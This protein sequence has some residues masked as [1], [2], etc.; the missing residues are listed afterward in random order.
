M[1]DIASRWSMGTHLTLPLPFNSFRLP[2]ICKNKVEHLIFKH[3]V[4]YTWCW[5]LQVYSNHP[6]TFSHIH[7]PINIL[8]CNDFLPKHGINYCKY[9]FRDVAT[10]YFTQNQLLQLVTSHHLF[11]QLLKKISK[12]SIGCVAKLQ[13][14][15]AQRH[16]V[17]FWPP[18]CQPKGGCLK[19]NN[20][21]VLTNMWHQTLDALSVTYQLIGRVDFSHWCQD[22][23][24]AYILNTP[25]SRFL[26]QSS[27]QTSEYIQ[28]KDV[29][30]MW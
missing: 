13:T 10:S 19:N 27:H 7:N 9:Q 12:L 28:R 23:I 25:G 17:K 3:S 8:N 4:R 14:H 24:L 30:K 26:C 21:F 22:D 11:D 2:T 5:I 15:H 18:G 6:F 29:L 16:V 20:G 1:P